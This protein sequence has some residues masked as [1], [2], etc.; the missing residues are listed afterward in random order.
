MSFFTH[1]VAELWSAMAELTV[2]DVDPANPCQDHNSVGRALMQ[3]Q[4]G[5]TKLEVTV[6]AGQVSPMEDR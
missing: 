3:P 5:G 4:I 1:Q 2:E 6:R